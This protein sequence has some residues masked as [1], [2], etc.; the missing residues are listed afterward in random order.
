VWSTP[1]INYHLE[2][3]QLTTAKPKSEEEAKMPSQKSIY[4]SGQG[5]ASDDGGATQEGANG[6]YVA[7]WLPFDF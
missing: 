1:K 3:R 2:G 7:A 6:I 4:G 5:G